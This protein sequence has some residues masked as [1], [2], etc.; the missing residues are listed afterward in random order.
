MSEEI[1]FIDTPEQINKCLNCAKPE[2]DDCARRCVE[3][4]PVY[5]HTLPVDHEYFMELYEAGLSDTEMAKAMNRTRGTIA[6]HRASHGL[7]PNSNYFRF[8][9]I[10][11]DLYAK[12]MTDTEI[13][14]ATGKTTNAVSC[15]RNR[16]KLKRNV[17]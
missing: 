2:C 6:Y 14:E 15:Y 11:N 9:A 13:A 16:K 5:A 4:E 3:G 7:K 10:F 17:K 1:D 8:E 12:G